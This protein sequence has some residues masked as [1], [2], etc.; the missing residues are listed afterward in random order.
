M[1]VVGAARSGIAAAELLA[2]RGA[3]VTL[4]ESRSTFD[5]MARLENA[6]V[7]IERGGHER[8]TLAAAEL[9]VVSP[10]VPIEQPILHRLGQVLF[11]DFV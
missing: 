11:A 3:I 1:V 2:K 9:V 8:D 7:Q 5:S 4:T 6:G 10:G